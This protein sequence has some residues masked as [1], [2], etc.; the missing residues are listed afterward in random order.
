MSAE[1]LRPAIRQVLDPDF[2]DSPDKF[3]TVRVL[4]PGAEREPKQGEELQLMEAMAIQVSVNKDTI[5]KV[6]LKRTY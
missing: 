5:S 1:E 4:K 6:V 2:A 3:G